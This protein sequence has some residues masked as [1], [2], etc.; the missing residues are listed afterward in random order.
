MMSLPHGENKIYKSLILEST[1]PRCTINDVLVWHGPEQKSFTIHHDIISIISRR[2]DYFNDLDSEKAAYLTEQQPYVFS[3]YLHCADFDRLPKEVA[4]D[5]ASAD[6]NGDLESVKATGILFASLV[7]LYIL[8]AELE[9]HIT[10]NMVI[11]KV[12]RFSND[13]LA[14][15]LCELVDL[16]Y[17]TYG[18]SS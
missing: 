15:D 18:N 7:K 13:L 5:S 8:A 2:T 17:K 14:A 11:D 10:M 4:G 16:A 12:V 3:Q 9:D 6:Y 1:N